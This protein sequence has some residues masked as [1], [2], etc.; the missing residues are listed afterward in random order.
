MD[1]AALSQAAAQQVMEAARF[2]KD[3]DRVLEKEQAQDVRT[4]FGRAVV[5]FSR[6]I[7]VVRGTAAVALSLFS[8]IIAIRSLMFFQKKLI[9][10]LF[11]KLRERLAKRYG[12]K[13]AEH[14]ATRILLY[15]AKK[16]V[17]K[18]AK[19]PL[20]RFLRHEIRK[21]IGEAVAG[22][23]AEALE[24]IVICIFANMFTKSWDTIVSGTTR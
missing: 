6:T 20:K 14:V 15:L 16:G 24:N 19:A 9:S 3:L 12:Q 10:F 11:K 4:R 1:R 17:G 7:A 18:L 22:E 23:Q 5:E 8:I 13:V 2:F 21:A